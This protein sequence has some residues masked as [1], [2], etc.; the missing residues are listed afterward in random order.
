MSRGPLV[1]VCCAF[2]S[3]TRVKDVPAHDEGKGHYCPEHAVFQDRDPRRVTVTALE[4]ALADLRQ[5]TSELVRWPFETMHNLLGFLQGVIYG[6]AMSGN[7]KTTLVAPV[8]YR[9]AEQG[10]RPWVMPTEAL[11]KGLLVR[12][13]CER[14]NINTDEV[15]SKR[16]RARAEGGE[17]YALHCLEQLDA[18]FRRLSREVTNGGTTL[19][20]EPVTMLNRTR[21]N[22]SLEAAYQF[23]SKVVIV[24]HT[25][26][27]QPER[28][29][30]ANDTSTEI[31]QDALQF[32]Q[33]TGIPIWMLTQ[34]N[35]RAAR[36]TPLPQYKPPETD[37][38]WM[39]GVKTHVAHTIF[40]IFRPLDPNADP[41]LMTRVKDRNAEPWR[42]ALL[43]TMGISEMK[44]RHSGNKRDRVIHLGIEKGRL[45]DL[46]EYD[47]PQNAGVR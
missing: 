38:L 37:W 8:V 18:E 5:P 16:L 15:M 10:L 28:G 7:G 21:F 45:A 19:G 33:D 12:L 44:G 36:G 14:L 46:P 40:G 4:S 34:L 27:I 29:S 47:Q 9:W 13:A 26:Q 3:C 39:P 30:N 42:V 35:A 17:A 20:I 23:G 43:N 1:S 6:A 41:E 31:Q 22:Q 2:E 24:D 25:D 32:T 11:P